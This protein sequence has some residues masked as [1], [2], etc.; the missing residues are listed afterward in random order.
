MSARPIGKHWFSKMSV[1]QFQE[2][3]TLPKT[4]PATRKRPWHFDLGTQI[5]RNRKKNSR[6]GNQN[7]FRGISLIGQIS[8][9]L[10]IQDGSPKKYINTTWISTTTK[11]LIRI[12]ENHK[13]KQMKHTKSNHMFWFQPPRKHQTWS[14]KK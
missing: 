4:R 10:L 13:P 9:Q 1:L 12:I 11:Y 6:D 7:M 2:P 5:G 14:Q 3:F 8:S